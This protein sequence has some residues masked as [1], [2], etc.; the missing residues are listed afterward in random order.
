MGCTVGAVGLFYESGAHFRLNIRIGK[1][2]R[3]IPRLLPVISD[4]VVRAE[5]N[6]PMHDYSGLAEPYLI[7]DTY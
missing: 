6:S 3:Q 4:D 1:L 7:G 2:V 5:T